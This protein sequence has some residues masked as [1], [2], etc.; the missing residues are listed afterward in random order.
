MPFF[1]CQNCHLPLA[2]F[3]EKMTIFGIFFEKNVKF[4]ATFWQSNGNFPESQQLTYSQGTNASLDLD[5]TGVR[6]PELEA[7]EGRFAA[8]VS[9]YFSKPCKAFSDKLKRKRKQLDLLLVVKIAVSSK[10]FL[11]I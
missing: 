8:K 4:L 2:I 1:K 7:G 10:H 11:S 9:L 5:R 6:E 3:W